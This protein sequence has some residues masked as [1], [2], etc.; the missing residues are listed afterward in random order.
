MQVLRPL[1]QS[2][3]FLV[4]S[5]RLEARRLRAGGVVAGLLLLT[6]GIVMIPAPL[7]TQAQGVVW[8]DDEGQLVAGAEGFVAEVVV[9]SGSAVS[10]GDLLLQLSNDELDSERKRLE[11]RLQELRIERHAQRQRSRVR[12]AMV[13]DD[14]GA[15]E[16]ELD[17]V[18]ERI[19]A[20]S[21]TSATAGRFIPVNPHSLENRY[22]KQGDVLGYVLRPG[23]PLIRAVIEQDKVGLMKSAPPQIAVM[24]ADRLGERIPAEFVREV[25]AGSTVLPSAA[26]GAGSGGRIAV[27]LRDESGQ[28]AVEKVFQ[29][30]LSIPEDQPT[31]GVGARAFV[32]LDHGSEP[33]WRQW[34]RS[35]RQLLLSRL[36]V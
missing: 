14:I 4:T 18:R 10:P 7:V 25:P 29:F 16:S 11:A 3:R 31:A 24:F 17:Q 15:V 30:D 9:A 2:L 34:S 6:L 13:E 32:R 36:D 26:L 5:E 20:L 8:I 35:V 23:R 19:A 22:V 12:A 21:I 27:D 1:Y 33:L 28:T